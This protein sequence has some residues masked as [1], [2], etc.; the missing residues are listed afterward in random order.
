MQIKIIAVGKLKEKYWREAGAE[1]LKRLRP[2][3]K[4]EVIEVDEERIADRPSP[5]EI[6]TGITREGE[7]IKKTLS[8]LD[9]T[10][11]LAIEG[12][13]LTS[14]ELAAL[15]GKLALEGKSQ[16]AFVI[17]GSHGLAPDVTKRGDYLLS[18]SPLTFP[19][20]LMRVL[21]LE[22]LYRGFKIQ[23]GEPYHK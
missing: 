4:V 6:Q 3:A 2:Y 14:E 15:L 16:L 7:R 11:P 5:A 19:H 21:L 10:I 13:M 9:Y 20:Q 12:K 18:F 23:K 8:P 1:Y 17:G 22:Q